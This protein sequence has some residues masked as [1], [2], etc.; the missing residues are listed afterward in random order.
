MYKKN[1]LFD[2]GYHLLVFLAFTELTPHT[3]THGA[4]KKKTQHFLSHTA[5]YATPLV[6]ATRNEPFSTQFAETLD[7]AS[8]CHQ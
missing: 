1:A 6:E 2:I 8:S 5:L 4:V 7:E 3:P